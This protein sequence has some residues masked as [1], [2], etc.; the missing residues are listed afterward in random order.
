V[1][2]RLLEHLHGHLA[3]LATAALVHPALSLRNPRRRAVLSCSLATLLAWIAGV[4]GAVVYP[5]YRRLLKRAIYVGDFR[6]GQLFER[7][8]H[9]AFAALGL[10]LAGLV[11]HL[12]AGG[13]DEA[14]RSRARAA[15]WAYVAAAALAIAVAVMGV[16]VAI[17]KTF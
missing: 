15:H 6:T 7:K 3:V 10:S 1:S 16:R 13:A 2:P 12:S 5:D 11:L 14:S 9:L 8:E 4:L 17:V